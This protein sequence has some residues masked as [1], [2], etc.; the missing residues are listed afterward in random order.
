MTEGEPRGLSGKDVAPLG[1]ISNSPDKPI[2]TQAKLDSVDLILIRQGAP[3]TAAN[4]EGM[5]EIIGHMK[6]HRS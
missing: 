4:R 2:N 3:L 5:R 6:T 1:N